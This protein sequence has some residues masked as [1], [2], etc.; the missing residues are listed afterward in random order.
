MAENCDFFPPHS[1]LTPSIVVNCL[2]FL[3][4]PFTAKIGVLELSVGDFV[5]EACVVLIQ[6]QRV[7]GGQT[8]GRTDGS[9]DPS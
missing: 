9:H 5:I 6:C 7:T 1:R 8:D 4:E 3:N 2:E